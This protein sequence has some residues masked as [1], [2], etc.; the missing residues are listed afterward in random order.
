[1]SKYYYSLGVM[2]GTSGDGVDASIIQ[3][4]GVS[5]YKVILDK[6][7]EYPKGIYE[8][9][10]KLRNKIKSSKN[11][12]KLSKEIK[13][14]E[15]EIT[16]FHA[17]AVNQI[18]EKI[19]V[20]EFNPDFDVDFIGFHGQTIYHNAKE[21]ISRQLGDGKLLSDLTKK[22]VVY[23][24][25]QNDLKNGGQGAPLTPV[26]HKLFAEDQ[27]LDLPAII[28][29]IGGIANMTYINHKKNIFSYDIGPGN[30]L[31][32]K[33]IRSRSKKKYDKNGKLARLGKTNS[34]ILDR[35]DKYFVSKFYGKKKLS[36]DLV[37]FNLSC[38]GSLSLKDGAST[39]TELTAILLADQI[40][41]YIWNKFR[42]FNRKKL[43]RSRKRLV[44][45]IFLCGGGRKNKTLIQNIVKKFHPNTHYFID[46]FEPI[47]FF[48]N[49]N[50][51]FIES[52]AFAYLA[53][54]SYL[55][56]PISFPST[57]G[58]SKPCTGG[59]IVKN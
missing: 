37:D 44:T 14:I 24:F 13:N 18:L 30:C 35:C 28:L 15:R 53:I 1:M 31:I 32:D 46:L 48:P 41:T 39:L 40:E 8:N 11:L 22:T 57:T 38:A 43:L 56:L 2:S 42:K 17:K 29:N 36:Y 4:D 34:K 5:K 21:K 59:V 23:D 20:K 33:W 55:K 51:D 10:T 12:K 45:N 50:G 27:K 54:R 6:Y 26:F 58:V 52:Q 19:K 47:D 16:L 9:L 7:F 49:T 3:S 25:R